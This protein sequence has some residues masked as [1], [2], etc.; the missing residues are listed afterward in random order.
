MRTLACDVCH[1]IIEAPVSGRNYYHMAHRDVCETCHDKLEVQI[2][3]TVRT[4]EP[5]AYDWYSKLVQES[6]EKAVQKGK[7]DVK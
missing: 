4:K 2:K 5:F 6:I 3:P 1:N 7:F